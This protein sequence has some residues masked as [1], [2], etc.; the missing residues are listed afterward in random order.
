M[1]VRRLADELCD[2]RLLLLGGGGYNPANVCVAWSAIALTVAGLPL[3]EAIPEA[4][5][6]RFADAYHR[7]APERLSEPPTTSTRALRATRDT[8]EE[9]RRRSPLLGGADA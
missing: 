4:W 3:P 1:G 7:P 8:V 9:L 6:S 5:R 2:G